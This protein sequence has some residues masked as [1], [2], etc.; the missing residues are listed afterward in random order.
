MGQTAYATK[1]IKPKKKCCKDSPYRCKKCPVVLKKLE[2]QGLAQ[3]QGKHVV[4]SLD[5]TK[6]QFKAARKR[7]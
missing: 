2:R 7:G 1:P 5:L 3:R 4:L 6:A